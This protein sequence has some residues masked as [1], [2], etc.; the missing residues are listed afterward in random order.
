MPESSTIEK[1]VLGLL[2][3]QGCYTPCWDIKHNWK[4]QSS[5][6]IATQ[7]TNWQ[8]SATCNKTKNFDRI[9]KITTKLKFATK[10]KFVLNQKLQQISNSHWAEQFQKKTWKCKEP[11]NDEIKNCKKS[12]NFSKRFNKS[13]TEKNLS[14]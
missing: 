6:K 5:W 10:L 14:H 11:K 13:S 9:E 2:K 8:G 3:G 7:Y 12:E 4:F 1:N